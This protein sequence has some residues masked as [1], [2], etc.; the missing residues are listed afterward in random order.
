MADAAP[1]IPAT[2]HPDGKQMI[3][4]RDLLAQWV[5]LAPERLVFV[6]LTNSDI[7]RPHQMPPKGRIEVRGS[8]GRIGMV[9]KQSGRGGIRL[10]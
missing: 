1:A 10:K 6:S 2:C 9:E 4:G 8:G 7:I 5:A 3:Q